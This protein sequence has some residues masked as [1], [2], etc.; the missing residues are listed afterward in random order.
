[1]VFG[2]SQYQQI[3][4][5]KQTNSELSF[6]DTP[7]QEILVKSMMK[8]WSTFAKD[9]ENGLE[10]DLK[11]PVYDPTSRFFSIRRC[12]VIVLTFPFS[13]VEATLIRF[14]DVNSSSIDFVHPST[15]DGSCT[16]INSL[17]NYFG[18]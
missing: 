15:T 18:I 2:S 12:R 5:S 3:Y 1:L 10:N 17:G 14:G 6:P 8:A 4:Y 13:L 7:E 16:V 9:P 11:Y